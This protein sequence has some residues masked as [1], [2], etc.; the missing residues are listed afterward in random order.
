M[1]HLIDAEKFAKRLLDTAGQLTAEAADLISVGHHTEA[2][3]RLIQAD[4]F[5]HLAGCVMK[6]STE[7]DI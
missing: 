7:R 2:G 6:S 4:V 5:N 3:P 1:T